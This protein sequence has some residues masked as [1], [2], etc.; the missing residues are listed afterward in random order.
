MSTDVN[1]AKHAIHDK[2]ESQIKTAEAKLDTLKARAETAKANVEIKA[3]AEL[4][5]RKRGIQQKLQE[6]KK[7]GED[8]VG[9]SESRSRGTDRRL[10][11]VGEEH[12]IEGE[13][14]LKCEGALVVRRRIKKSAPV[15]RGRTPETSSSAT[16]SAWTPVRPSDWLV[17]FGFFTNRLWQGREAHARSCTRAFPRRVAGPGALPGFDDSGDAPVAPL[18]QVSGRVALPLLRQGMRRLTA[19]TMSL[20]AALL[21]P[22]AL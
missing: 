15:I 11:E 13:G 6:L 10:R 17:F 21:E 7:S 3:I 20:P 5:T 19:G 22:R 2:L 8:L 18:D 1:L 9:A 14:K 16:G 4:L 12:R